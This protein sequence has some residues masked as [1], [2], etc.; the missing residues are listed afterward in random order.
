MATARQRHEGAAPG[1]D[2]SR[3]IQRT[4]RVGSVQNARAANDNTGSRSQENEYRGI[5]NVRTDRRRTVTDNGVPERFTRPGGVAEQFEEKQSLPARTYNAKE[6]K[7]K[8]HE[9]KETFQERQ[10]AFKQV[11]KRIKSLKIRTGGHRRGVVRR[12][13]G[14]GRWAGLGVLWL[15]YTV[16]LP[17][18]LASAM[19]YGVSAAYEEYIGSD[20]IAGEAVSTIQDWIN[21]GSNFLFGIDILPSADDMAFIFW[22]LTTIISI[23]MFLIFWAWFRIQGIRPFGTMMS[24]FVSSLCLALSI[25]P[26]TNIFPWIICW[27]LYVNINSLFLRH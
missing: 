27:F 24:F 8:M 22:G 20:S 15:A 3:G 10:K 14:F 6:E 9:E 12:T 1:R 21:A 19:M 16:T 5:D 7:V 25:L 4:Q 18:A 13:T 2:D 23:S 17:L 26:F 11:Q